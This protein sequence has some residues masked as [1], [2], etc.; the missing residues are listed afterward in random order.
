MVLVVV[1]ALLR[2]LLW[3]A[4]L[5]LA[6]VV[7]AVVV[8]GAVGVTFTRRSGR[9]RSCSGMQEEEPET[10]PAPELAPTL[11]SEVHSTLHRLK[12]GNS[13]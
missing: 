10:G 7:V 4:L 12:L 6:D 13:H 3:Q 2:P 8:A 5:L 11:C 1:V 9:G